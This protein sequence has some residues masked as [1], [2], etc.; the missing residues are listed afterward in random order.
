VGSAAPQL[1]SIIMELEEIGP[2]LSGSAFGALFTFN[3]I[4][5]FLVPWLMG[6][7]M[8]AFNAA[9][10]IYAIALL[11]LI[12]PALVLFL[13]ETGWRGRSSS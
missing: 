13:R 2:A 9:A 5:G 8:T 1:R 10:G 4:G 12:P 7:V 11:A 3:R 6:A